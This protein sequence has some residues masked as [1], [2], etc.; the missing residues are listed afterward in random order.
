MLAFYQETLTRLPG[1]ALASLYGI[2]E[3][4]W[5][6]F[7]LG[8]ETPSSSVQRRRVPRL[9]CSS[10][11][12]SHCLSRRRWNEFLRGFKIKLLYLGCV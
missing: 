9:F 4:I 10:G 11:G 8:A 12:Q 2:L 5:G 3:E 6:P 7:R 1:A